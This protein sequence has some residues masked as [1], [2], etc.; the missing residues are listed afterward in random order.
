MKW[1]RTLYSSSSHRV[2]G[3]SAHGMPTNRLK[4]SNQEGRQLQRKRRQNV[5][6]LIDFWGL[7]DPSNTVI[8]DS[9]LFD[10]VRLLQTGISSSN[11]TLFNV[12][13]GLPYQYANLGL[14]AFTSLSDDYDEY[15]NK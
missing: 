10:D 8:V 13:E 7:R 11:D 6:F 15:Q 12:V 9:N 1:Y 14:T 4:T 5:E 2:V 3:I